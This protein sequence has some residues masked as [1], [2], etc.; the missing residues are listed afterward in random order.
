MTAEL[1]VQSIGYNDFRA[2][3]ERYPSV[4][5]DKLTDLDEQRYVSIPAN[6]AKLAQVEEAHLTKQELVTLVEWKVSHGKFRPSLKKLAQENDEERVEAVTK[7]AFDDGDTGKAL[8][9][10]CTLRGVGPAT[11]SL[12]LSVRKID[13]VPFFSDELFRWCSWE[14][15]PGSGWDRGIKYN[16]KEY[17]ELTKA[18]DEL[19]SRFST[20]GQSVSAVDCEKVAYVL[21]KTEVDLS[22]QLATASTPPESSKQATQATAITASD[23]GEDTTAPDPASKTSRKRARKDD[24]VAD[25]TSAPRRSTRS[26]K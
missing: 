26:K 11:A 4:R 20:D 24:D 19:R 3:L 1:D 25:E 22:V 6:L 23:T 17:A 14:D 18:V 5:P 12:L 15:K 2:V 16:N 13:D 9:H 7:T 10:L 8:K 21:G